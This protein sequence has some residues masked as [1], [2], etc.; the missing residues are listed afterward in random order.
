MPSILR[1][2]IERKRHRLAEAIGRVGRGE[3]KSRAADSPPSRDFAGALR[4]GPVRVIAEMKRRSPSR[5][6]IREDFDVVSLAAAY[7]AGGA[8]ALSI[9][10][11]E[12]FFEGSL[13]YVREVRSRTPLPILRKDFLFDP[14]QIYE[15]REA[16]ADAVLLIVAALGQSELCEL[17]ALASELG[18]SALVEVHTEEELERALKSEADLIGI[19]N[20]DLNTFEVR[21]ETAEELAGRVPAGRLIVAESGI[22]GPADVRRLAGAGIDAFLI[23][24]HFMRA[25]DI[26]AAVRAI[27]GAAT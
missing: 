23:G 14:Y 16:G 19:N 24:E 7:G 11:E 12:D 1:R 5:G 27:K 2:I 4:G 15:A 13:E 21:L 17:T 8:D 18:L 26:P 3:M 6:L 25:P 9:L 10:T 20:R 22:H